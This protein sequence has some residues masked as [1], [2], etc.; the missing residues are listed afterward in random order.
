[1]GAFPI[2]LDAPVFDL[3]PRMVERSEDV[4]IQAPSRK[5]A[6]KL[7]ICAFW[8]G[9]SGSMNSNRTPCS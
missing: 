3:E 8:I 5:R 6:L 7:S 2:V 4:F 1:M 9:L